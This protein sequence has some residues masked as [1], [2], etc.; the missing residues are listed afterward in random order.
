MFQFN[1]LDNN[2]TTPLA[3]LETIPCNSHNAKEIP[4]SNSPVT[5]NSYETKS[6]SYSDTLNIRLVTDVTLA[7]DSLL[8]AAESNRTDLQVGIYEGGLKVWECTHDLANFIVNENIELNQRRVLDLGCGSGIIGIVARMSGADVCFQ[9]YNEDVIT[10]FTIPN[11][12][13]NS[14]VGECRFYA[15]DW[16]SFASIVGAKYDVIFTCETVYNPDNYRKLCRVFSN[17][18]QPNGIMYPFKH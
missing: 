1:F 17:C 18:L 6:I 9:D 11:V 16:E 7:P 4:V 8:C 13:L 10:H 14:E 12:C 15:G 5:P 3:A 2:S